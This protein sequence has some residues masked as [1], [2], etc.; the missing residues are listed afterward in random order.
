MSCAP[1]RRVSSLGCA[2]SQLAA[3]RGIVSRGFC[4]WIVEH[5]E[6]RESEREE[7]GEN[8]AELR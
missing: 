3:K 2:C 8:L 5:K 4:G 6:D 7:G 1:L